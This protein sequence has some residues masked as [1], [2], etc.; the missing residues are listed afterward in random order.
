MPPCRRL[1]C[2]HCLGASG[3]VYS[4]SQKAF[5]SCP[6]TPL[7]TP[8]LPL[9]PQ[10]HKLCLPTHPRNS[11][12]LPPALLSSPPIQ[13]FLSSGN[14]QK[15]TWLSIHQNGWHR[16]QR[17]PVHKP[18]GTTT[19]STSAVCASTEPAPMGAACP[20]DAALC[21]SACGRHMPQTAVP[22]WGRVMC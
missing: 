8:S 15:K 9:A 14:N 19:S 11:K 4:V 12:D 3:L 16:S 22:R 10:H 17:G 7:L 21:S 18:T 13:S 1:H 20:C 6:A 5:C 2:L